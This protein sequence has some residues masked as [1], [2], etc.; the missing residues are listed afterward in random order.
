MRAHLRHGV[1]QSVA[2]GDAAQVD[3]LL[4]RQ[5]RVG[6]EDERAGRGDGLAGVALAG[7]EER[8]GAEG[9]RRLGRD[10]EG[11]E[12]GEDVLCDG[13]LGR[14]DGGGGR[15][16]AVARAERAVEEEEA[17]AAV[18]RVGVGRQGERGG[19]GGVGDGVAGAGQGEDVGADLEE[20]AGHGGRTWAA[21]EPD[22]ERRGGRRRHRAGGL[23]EGVVERCVGYW[24]REVAGLCWQRFSGE[25]AGRG[26]RGG[27]AGEEDDDEAKGKKRRSCHCHCL[28]D[29][30][31]DLL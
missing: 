13:E 7:E 28:A 23:V 17:E 6:G 1:H 18:P 16:R 2:D 12:R 14:G 3:P 11:L 19:G 30:C 31:L 4:L 8:A 25:Y 26:C 9:R 10:E 29:V 24:D 15:R 5:C 22:Q 20:V 21:L 27:G